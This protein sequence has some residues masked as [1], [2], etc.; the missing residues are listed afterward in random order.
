VDQ[1]QADRERAG[2]HQFHQRQSSRVWTHGEGVWL[3]DDEGRRFLDGSGGPMVVNIGHGREEVAEAAAQQIRTLGYAMPGYALDARTEL[4][5]RIE[6]LTPPGLNRVWF[7]SGGSEAVE[8]ATKF[9]RQAQTLRGF[10]GKYKV[11]GRR[12]SYHGSTLFTLSIGG[13]QSRR[14]PYLPML[15][16]MPHIVDCNCYRCPFGKTYPECGLACADDLEARIIAEGPE[17]VAAF[18]A[19]PVVAAAAG[20]VPPPSGDYFQRIREIC[21]KYDVL[22]IADEIVTGFGRTGMPFAMQHWG[23]RPDIIVF[24]KGVAS[25]YA[26]LAGFIAADELVEP[27]DDAGE[28]FNTIFTYSAHPVSCAIGA[29]VQEIVERERLI[30]RSRELGD[31][32]GERLESLNEI[33]IVGNVRGMGL[34]RGVEIVRNQETG[35]PFPADLDVPNDVQREM[36]RRGVLHYQGN[37]RDEEGGGAQVILAPPFII[38]REEI[39]LLVDTLAEVLWDRHRAYSERGAAAG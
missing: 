33:P 1:K 3:F 30:E 36:Y 4:A 17:T 18:I 29:K 39:D 5:E 14:D 16:P 19:E 24:A 7:G 9:A 37:W 38:E 25:G 2:R 12:N 34:L 11:I 8:A 28:M 22:F 32:L 26:P 20:A 27:F 31:Y 23:V 15:S 10:P 35:E 13:F 6:A 21:T